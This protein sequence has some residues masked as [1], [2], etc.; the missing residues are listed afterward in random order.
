M[1]DDNKGT[2]KPNNELGFLYKKCKKIRP[3]VISSLVFVPEY[4]DAI[5][6]YGGFINDEVLYEIIREKFME[7][8]GNGNGYRTARSIINKISKDVK[9]DTFAWKCD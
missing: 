3:S 9:G 7:M 2:L 5:K 1:S 6:A 8:C 4:I